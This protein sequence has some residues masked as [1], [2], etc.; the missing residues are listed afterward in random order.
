DDRAHHTP[1]VACDEDVRERVE[2]RVEGGVAG[3][4]M[5]EFGGADLV[6]PTRDGNGANRA[7]VRFGGA[8]RR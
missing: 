8:L 1:E 2:K 4:R 7:E 3:R 6:R 5:R